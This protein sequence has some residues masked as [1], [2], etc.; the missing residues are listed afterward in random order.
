VHGHVPERIRRQIG[1]GGIEPGAALPPERELARL[2]GVGRA[3]VQQAVGLLE[4]D[5]LIET[6]RGRA[7]GS[8][9]QALDAEVAAAEVRAR[10]ADIAAT[11]DFRLVVEPAAAALAGKHRRRAELAGVSRLPQPRSVDPG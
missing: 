3:T 2:F 10:A 5:R 9:V 7:G 1:V 6:R 8:F 4:A 11:L